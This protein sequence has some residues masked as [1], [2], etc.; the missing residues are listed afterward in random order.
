[1]FA[2]ADRWHDPGLDERKI[3]AVNPGP[4][5]RNY[6]RSVISTR[7]NVRVKRDEAAMKIKIFAITAVLAA[8]V[9]GAAMA[10]YACPAGY[11]YSAGTCQPA[12]PGGYS[13]PVSGAV[14][15]TAAG[16]ASGNAAAGPV[17]AI[18]GGALGTAT[19]A[20]GGAA[21][22]VTGVTGNCAVGYHFA[23]GYC[24]PNR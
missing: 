3:G 22:T 24:Y 8:G 15:G 1:L 19:G 20:V 10:Q 2:Q 17:G 4:M 12:A 9:S 11:I 21:N 23:N 6:I 5:D 16:A 13:N 14:N 7:C 18:V